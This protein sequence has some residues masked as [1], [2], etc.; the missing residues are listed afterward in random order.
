MTPKSKAMTVLAIHDAAGTI[1][2][3]V[4]CPQNAPRPVV[5][6]RPGRSMTEINLPRG[7]DA[8]DLQ[9][10]ARLGELTRSYRIEV[11]NKGTLAPREKAK[12]KA[13]TR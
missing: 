10:T 13:K 8:A 4:T 2:E 6:T 7:W 1:F 12:A 11:P 5:A 3:V 9:N